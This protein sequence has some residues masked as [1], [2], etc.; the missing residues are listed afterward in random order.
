MA[1]PPQPPI[2]PMLDFS[3]GPLVEKF[4]NETLGV[5]YRIAAV[6]TTSTYYGQD[7]MYGHQMWDLF[8]I[9]G[10]PLE[11][12]GYPPPG[13][14]RTYNDRGEAYEDLFDELME[15]YED[16]QRRYEMVTGSPLP[17]S[18][19]PEMLSLRHVVAAREAARSPVPAGDPWVRAFTPFGVTVNING[20][21]QRAP[22]AAFPD[23]PS[24]FFGRDA[25][26]SSRMPNGIPPSTPGRSFTNAARSGSYQRANA[27]QTNTAASA[28]QRP[29]ASLIQPGT[30]G[31]PASQQ[32]M[33]RPSVFQPQC[34]GS[35][36][37]SNAFQHQG[38]YQ[39][40]SPWQHQ[41]PRSGSFDRP[42]SYVPSGL[43]QQPSRS[44]HDAE[45]AAANLEKMMEH[46]KKL[47][48][49]FEKMMAA[50]KPA[51]A[52][53]AKDNNEQAQAQVQAPASVPDADAPKYSGKGK[54]RAGCPPRL[55]PSVEDADDAADPS[56]S[57]TQTHNE[58]SVNP[59]D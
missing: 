53:E 36:H 17:R 42:A 31:Q 10:N 8:P 54:Q 25:H 51:L 32:P 28:A 44:T 49:E 20:R 47:Q 5:V 16:L 34:Y 24:V 59:E 15:N 56:A 52:E 4:V 48:A 27:S 40:G 33:R 18:R 14:C 13:R 55:V 43:S 2:D 37:V 38:S 57:E 22:S 45:E 26:G 6:S 12:Y 9:Y 50:A 30:A 35:G 21:A 58:N 23:L 19:T 7:L 41:T 39:G 11:A 3:Y 46:T 1:L 29:T